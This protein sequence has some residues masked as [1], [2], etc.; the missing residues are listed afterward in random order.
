MKCV[1]GCYPVPQETLLWRLQFAQPAL[2]GQD[3]ATPALM[4]VPWRVLGTGRELEQALWPLLL[5]SLAPAAAGG[6]PAVLAFRQCG[7]SVDPVWC[8]L[9][10]CTGLPQRSSLLFPGCKTAK[11]LCY[12]DTLGRALHSL[13]SRGQEA[14][15]SLPRHP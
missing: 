6:R 2:W 1:D 8:C 11:T 13:L 5:H 7:R 12:T 14:A 3:M 15:A 10:K 9:Q 4:G